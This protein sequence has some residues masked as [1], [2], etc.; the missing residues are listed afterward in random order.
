MT[1]NKNYEVLENAYKFQSAGK[2]KFKA[3][4]RIDH[5]ANVF[6]RQQEGYFIP[7]KI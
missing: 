6:L 7:R 1:N 2:I 3:F 4:P 5:P